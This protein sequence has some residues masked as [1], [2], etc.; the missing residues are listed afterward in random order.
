MMGS[1]FLLQKIL[2]SVMVKDS[3]LSPNLV[4]GYMSSLRGYKDLPE[5]PKEESKV[6]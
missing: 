4:S 5:P 6:V 1:K 3:L 2:G